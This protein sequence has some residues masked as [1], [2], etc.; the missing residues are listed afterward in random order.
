MRPYDPSWRALLFPSS[1]TD[2][3]AHGR[4][5]GE[6]ALAAEL[7]RVA[8]IPFEH[9]AGARRASEILRGAGFARERFISA[10]GTECFVAHDID[11]KLTA[12]AFRGTAGLRDIVTDLM[13]WRVRWTPGGKVHAGF[14]YALRRIWPTL[15]LSLGDRE[16]RLIYTGHSLGAALATLAATLVPP[17][18]LYTFGSPRVGDARFVALL[19]DVRCVRTTGCSDLVCA[20]PPAW[21]GFRHCGP[22]AYVDR[23]GRTV[24]DP[25]PVLVRND[26]AIGRREYRRDFAWRLGTVWSRRLSDHAPVN[27]AS[28]AAAG[29]TEA[30]PQS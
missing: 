4:P 23:D 16:A 10:G 3:F 17:E 25:H 8:Y 21:L 11:A 29:G 26:Q 30:D 1:A 22:H 20:V 14:A 2:F 5:A 19:E 6:A 13:T 28:A 18:A 27:Y 9:E 15:V 7:A 12:V 24:A